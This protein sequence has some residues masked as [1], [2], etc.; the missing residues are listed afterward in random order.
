M[1]NT[2]VPQLQERVGRRLIFFPL[3]LQGHISPMLQ[4]ANILHSKGFSITILHLKLNSPNPANYPHFTFLPIDDDGSFSEINEAS[5]TDL[6]SLLITLN[7]KCIDPFKQ[8]LVQ[9]LADASGDPAACLISDAIF[10][11]TNDVCKSL[12]LPRIVLRTG[13][14]CSFLAFAAFPLL[15]QKGYLPV[16]DDRLEELVMELPPLRIKDLPVIKTAYPEQLYE[17]VERM[18]QETKASSGLIWNSFEELEE[19]AIAKLQQEFEIPIFPIGP[20]HKHS[21]SASSSSSSLIAEDHSS[22]SWLDKQ[23]PNSVIY[24]SFGSIAAIDED[25]FLEVAWGLANSK[26]PFLWVVR[27][28]LIHG[29]EWPEALPEGFLERVNGRGLIVKWAP[30]LEVLA[31]PSVGVFWTHNGWNSTLESVCEGVPMI[32]TPCFTDQLVNARYVSHVWNVGL[33]LENGLSRGKIEMAIKML[34]EER[35]GGEV[36]ERA[37]HYKEMANLCLKPGGSSY[38]S[39]NKL[40]NYI[41]FF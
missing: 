9:L 32:C 13:G 24:I 20:F 4:L 8:A 35:E 26:H 10:H 17:L 7:T 11:F 22:I 16:Q 15:L 25:E 41:S 34:M 38:D 23:E 31:H 14:V 5:K 12:N 30:Q 40:V 18:V 33:H 3:P 39:L 2:S 27:P 28:G 37:L 29:A 1:D 21:S 6:I 36:R 19:M